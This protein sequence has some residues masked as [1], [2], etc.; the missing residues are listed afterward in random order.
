MKK[1]LLAF[2][3]ISAQAALSANL[4]F[5][6]EP[7]ENRMENLEK[8]QA[9]SSVC[10]GI[11]KIVVDVKKIKTNR[12]AIDAQINQR[13]PDSAGIDAYYTEIE[14]FYQYQLKNRPEYK[15][16]EKRLCLYE[17][18]YIPSYLGH[19]KNFDQFEVYYYEYSAG[20]AHGMYSYGYYIF[21]DKD[22]IVYIEDLLTDEG[23][24]KLPELLEAAYRKWWD[25]PDG[26]PLPEEKRTEQTEGYIYTAKTQI[27]NL[28]FTEKGLIFSH[29]PYNAAPY[30]YGQVELLLPYEQLKGVLKDEYLP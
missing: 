16:T 6:I 25:A 8:M 14:D 9:Y 30:V 26:E 2:F 22:N 1:S 27:R 4:L 21:D 10:E 18:E 13:I 19:Y 24:K 29:S 11:A 7:V 3:L 17:L 12:P 5:S 15:E 20:A 23:I 28:F